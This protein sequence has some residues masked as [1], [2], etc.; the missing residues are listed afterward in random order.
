MVAAE[1]AYRAGAQGNSA[2]CYPL[3][4]VA[5]MVVVEQA[6]KGEVQGNSAES[7]SQ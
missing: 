3:S 7:Y 4:W 5:D 6:C 2:G 1:Q